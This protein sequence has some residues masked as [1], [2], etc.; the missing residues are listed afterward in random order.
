MTISNRN[1]LMMK[2][3]PIMLLTLQILES[4]E[5]T[6][7]F[8]DMDHHRTRQGLRDLNPMM[9]RDTFSPDKRD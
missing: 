3:A 7:G 8:T 2:T 1:L 5:I 6:D 9:E 4:R